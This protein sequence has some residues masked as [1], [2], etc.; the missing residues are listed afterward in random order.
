[1]TIAPWLLH[2]NEKSFIGISNIC[3]QITIALGEARSDRPNRDAG[4]FR[5]CRLQK[6]DALLKAFDNFNASPAE[7]GF[8]LDEEIGG[9]DVSIPDDVE[10]WVR[11]LNEE[12]REILADVLMRGILTDI[13]RRQCSEGIVALGRC[14]PD[15][16][17]G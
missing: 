14:F 12:E 7:R 4:W 13:L 11:R 8:D 15:L 16:Q 3:D 9:L 1:M 6:H 17:K 2:F 10:F 5:F